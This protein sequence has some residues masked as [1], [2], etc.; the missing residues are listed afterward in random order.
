MKYVTAHIVQVI[1]VALIVRI[2]PIDLVGYV[3]LFEF[4]LHKLATQLEKVILLGVQ[5]CILTSCSLFAVK[6]KIGFH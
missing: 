1:S 2:L 5:P 3:I 4:E 6:R